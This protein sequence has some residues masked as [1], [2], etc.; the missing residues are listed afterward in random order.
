MA[1]GERTTLLYQNTHSLNNKLLDLKTKI[2]VSQPC[3]DIILFSETWLQGDVLNSELGIVNFNI[4]RQGR[5]LKNNLSLRGG[6]VIICTKKLLN[7]MPVLDDCNVELCVVRVKFQPLN[8]IIVAA[9]L[10]AVSTALPSA[11]VC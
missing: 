1:M 4:R 3:P 8:V 9:N 5:S 6:V 2:H 7:A 11:A 10:P